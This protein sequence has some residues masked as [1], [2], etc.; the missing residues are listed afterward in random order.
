MWKP[1]EPSGRFGRWG[2]IASAL[3]T[4]ALLG[5]LIVGLILYWLVDAPVWI[6]VAVCVP[7]A[8][9]SIAWGFTDVDEDEPESESLEDFEGPHW[10]L[11]LPTSVGG[12]IVR[13]AAVWLSVGGAMGLGALLFVELLGMSEQDWAW[14][15]LPCFVLSVWAWFYE[16]VDED[17]RAELPDN[18]PVRNSANA[19]FH[20]SDTKA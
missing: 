18:A 13:V 14:A 17:D 7:L 2:Q 20:Q 5:F 15:L 9:F 11:N 19:R 4:F 10:V 16:P 1:D 3:A 8:V 6:L 12:W